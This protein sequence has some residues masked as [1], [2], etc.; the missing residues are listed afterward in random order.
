MV[1]RAARL[2]FGW[3]ETIGPVV[4]GPV[5]VGVLWDHATAANDAPT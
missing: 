5:T 4:I 2:L 3:I 1:R